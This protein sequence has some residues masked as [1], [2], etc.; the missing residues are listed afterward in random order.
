MRKLLFSLA[1]GIAVLM[2][3]V[4]LTA[5]VRP[6]QPLPDRG[7]AVSPFMEGWYANDDGSFTI[8]FGYLNRNREEVVRIPIG[9][10]NLIEPAR[11]SGMQPTVFLPGRNRGVFTVTIPAADP[12]A[13]LLWT[14]V[15]QNGEA[16]EVPGK[17]TSSAYEL[18]RLPRPAGSLPPR[19]ALGE[20]GPWGWDPSGVV[21]DQALTASVGQP[22]LLS[23]WVDDVSQRDPE[24]PRFEQAKSV[25]VV[26]M[27]HQAPP[28]GNVEFTR[29][30]STPVPPT[31]AEGD[32]E[33]RRRAPAP[34]PDEVMLPEGAGIAR[35]YATFSEPG[36]YLVRAQAD[37]WRSPD[38]SSGDQCCWS[39]AYMRVSVG[40]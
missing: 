14:I 6:L 4:L 28:S 35:V 40:R 23:V 12:D 17:T 8:S 22:I 7:L 16:H 26:W 27:P 20:N 10:R 13:Q 19:V 37:N 38:S 31:P 33:P 36:E 29:H 11:F 18:D 2:S 9:T 25:R 32:D 39:N 21:A 34:G 15:N 24:D 1:A 3:P 30:E 5:Q